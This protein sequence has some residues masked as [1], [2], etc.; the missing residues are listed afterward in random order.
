MFLSDLLRSRMAP[1]PA[2]H[3]DANTLAALSARSLSRRRRAIVF[4]HLAECEVCRD[5]LACY[6]ALPHFEN[7]NPAPLTVRPFGP[8]H[9]WQFKIAVGIACALM[10]FVAISPRLLHMESRARVAKN[11]LLASALV[12]RTTATY[13]PGAAIFHTASAHGISATRLSRHHSGKASDRRSALWSTVW[14]QPV[15]LVTSTFDAPRPHLPGPL[16]QARLTR[17]LNFAASFSMQ[18]AML[19]A[20]NQISV[21]TPLGERWITLDRVSTATWALF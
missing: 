12:E 11:P 1:H 7:K 16:G 10:L 18:E 14:F 15:R 9:P 20:L 5:W 19:P 4:A 3:L 2:G 17:N 6:S 8:M 21:H 13:Q